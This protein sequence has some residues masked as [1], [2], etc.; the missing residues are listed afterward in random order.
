MCRHCWDPLW[1]ANLP[2][3]RYQVEAPDGALADL[4]GMTTAAALAPE[5]GAALVPDFKGA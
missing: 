5:F 4:S 1:A 3:A 2:S